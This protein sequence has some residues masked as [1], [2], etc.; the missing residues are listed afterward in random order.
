MSATIESLSKY[1]DGHR[2]A[3]ITSSIS[4]VEVEYRVKVVSQHE[5]HYTFVYIA[6]GDYSV[7]VEVGMLV[8]EAIGSYRL[9]FRRQDGTW[10]GDYR[11]NGKML[12]FIATLV[13]AYL[14]DA[15]YAKKEAAKSP[16]QIAEE[17]AAREEAGNRVRNQAIASAAEKFLAEVLDRFVPETTVH[18][19]V[20]DARRALE[21]LIRE[22]QQGSIKTVAALAVKR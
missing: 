19:A 1:R 10:G 3:T 12:P 22:A 15:E 18:Y 20:E 4:G 13:H 8:K 21:V 16:E 5:G 7:Y 9:K 11:E 14:N 6:G 17:A 2:Y